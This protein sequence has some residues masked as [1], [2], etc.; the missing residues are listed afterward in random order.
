MKVGCLN[1]MPKVEEVAIAEDETVYFY[2]PATNE[3][4]GGGPRG[5]LDPFERKYMRLEKSA[6]QNSGE[7]NEGGNCEDGV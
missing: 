6:I 7:G 5:V 1:G 3:T 2:Q 4:F